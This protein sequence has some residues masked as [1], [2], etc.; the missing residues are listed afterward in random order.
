MVT[1]FIPEVNI[2]R[3]VITTNICHYLVPD[4]LIKLGVYEV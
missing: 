4:A 1:Y 2:D 3:E